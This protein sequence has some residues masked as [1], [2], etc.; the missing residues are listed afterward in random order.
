MTMI[1]KFA[2]Q[3]RVSHSF[4]DSE[5]DREELPSSESEQ[6]DDP[7]TLSDDDWDDDEEN[8]SENDTEIEE[9]DHSKSTSRQSNRA[10][11]F[12]RRY[13]AFHVSKHSLYVRVIAQDSNEESNSL[14]LRRP[15]RD[16]QPNQ[17]PNP[18]QSTQPPH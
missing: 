10:V 16:R 4:I 15:N 3:P 6:E 8:D 12:E 7:L 18:L 9:F 2:I 1:P 17:R 11:E 5:S 14:T 13:R